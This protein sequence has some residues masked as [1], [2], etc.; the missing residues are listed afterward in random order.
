MNNKAL[1]R[2][3]G[4]VI[5][6]FVWKL[7]VI[8]FST[9]F[10]KG[11]LLV[12]ILPIYMVS[13]LG[14]P[15]VIIG[16]AFALQYIGDNVFRTP[17]GWLVDKIGYRY[18]MVFGLLLTFVAV[19][20]L[21]LSESYIWIIIGCCI[22]GIGTSPLWPCVIT[23]A[24]EVAGEHARATIMSTVYIAWVTGVGLGPVTINFLV[25]DTFTLAF[26]ILIVIMV[27][28]TL[29]ALT[30]PSRNTSSKP[31]Q[32]GVKRDRIKEGAFSFRLDLDKVKTYFQ[33]VKASVQVSKLFFP[34]LFLQSFSIGLL[35]PVV[36]LYVRQVLKLSGTEYSLFLVF[37]GAF[38]VLLMMPIGKLVD[39]WGTK[40]FLHAGF[41]LS[42]SMLL[43]FTT[44]R[45]MPLLYMIVALI[46]IAYAMIIP[47][48]NALIAEAVPKEK[49]GAVWGFY[50]TIEG[51]G[52]ISGPIVSGKIWD[53]LGPASPF[54]ASGIV[55][56]ILLIVHILISSRNKLMVR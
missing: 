30:L 47:A 41:A 19:G 25:Q 49:R 33:E 8:M 22:L 45:S 56:I 38:T 21:A 10:V 51:F 14:L 42:A 20:I 34:A 50:L 3:K 28:V 23:G 11:A 5:T 24:T 44:I 9:E 55:L 26:R 12:S 48:W 17:L 16:W 15:A 6:P 27:L 54:I 32:E 40:W 4:I 13:T 2:R 39:R 1:P 31:V 46:G 7:L 18:S 29:V 37:G 36:T 53:E 35:T 52:M 43:I